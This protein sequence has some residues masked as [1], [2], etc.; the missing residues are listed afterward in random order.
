M[1]FFQA[2]PHPDDRKTRMS[3][4]LTREEEQ[5]MVIQE[6]ASIRKR[7]AARQAIHEH[8]ID[9]VGTASAIRDC[10]G[11]E[12]YDRPCIFFSCR[13]GKGSPLVKL[14]RKF[15]LYCMGGSWELAQN[16]PSKTCQFLRYHMGKNPANMGRRVRF[17]SEKRPRHGAVFSQE[18]TIDEL[19]MPY[20]LADNLVNSGLKNG[21]LDGTKVLKW[22]ASME[23]GVDDEFME[24]TARLL[25]WVRSWDS[26]A[27]MKKTSVF[28]PLSGEEALFSQ[29]F[30]QTERT[31]NSFQL[32]K[33]KTSLFR[34]KSRL[35]SGVLQSPYIAY[36]SMRG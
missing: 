36:E 33:R 22:F 23:T 31:S 1:S 25:H 3:N 4:K 26:A 11:N 2:Q 21:S 14:I 6:S 7:L 29:R 35:K 17:K 30:A 15:C 10:Q 9:C 19:P 13:M 18:S 28:Y 34:M 16:C 24:L 32:K 8:C 12:L 27:F 20:A 5:R